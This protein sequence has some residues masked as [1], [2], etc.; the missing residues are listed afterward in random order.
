MTQQNATI[1]RPQRIA[2]VLAGL[3]AAGAIG[4]AVLR[5]D[6]GSVRPSDAAMTAVIDAASI[7]DLEKAAA[8]SP[9]NSL[10]W[11]RLGLAY[12]E[13]ERFADAARAYDEATRLAPDTALLWSALGE[14]RVMASERDPMP[15][16]AIAAFK[17]AIAI[18]PADPRARYFLAVNR[19][20]KGDHRGAIDDWFALLKDTPADAPWR[21]DLIRTIEQVAKIH[22]LDV[23]E[24][25]A[26]TSSATPPSGASLPPVAQGI[27]GPSAQDLSNAARIPPGEQHKMAE[28]MVARLETRLE[29]DPS[30]IDGWIMLMR[31]RMTLG[32][33]EKAK[34]ALVDAV[35]ANP[36]KAD[37]LRQQAA[38][39]GIRW[40]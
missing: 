16:D 34:K 23:A 32:E 37:Y 36:A 29:D 9:E 18:D 31:S 13:A 1:F 40:N 25:L 19:D 15:S 14:A 38:I 5:Q 11:Q 27:P 17:K 2:L 33:P 7:S 3:V 21:G 12:F 22:E 6:G 28:G 4:V 35:A 30:N 26:E 8:D 10:V 24:K 39:L 20:L